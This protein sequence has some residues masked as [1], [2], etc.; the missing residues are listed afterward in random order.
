MIDFLRPRIATYKLPEFLCVMSELPLTPTGKV[1]K[2]PLRDIIADQQRA[3]R[4]MGRG[5]LVA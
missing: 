3:G 5:D 2:A 1:Q 4:V